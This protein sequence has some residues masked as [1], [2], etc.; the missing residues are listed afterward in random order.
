[1]LGLEKQRG[2][3]CLSLKYVHGRSIL[4]WRCAFG[5]QWE[6]RPENIVRGDWCPDCAGLN[7]TIEHMHVLAAEFRGRCLSA[8][9]V[10]AHTKLKWE[11]QNGHTWMAAP[12][13]V[14][15]GKWCSFCKGT[16]VHIQDMY[17]LAK[18]R[19]GMCLSSKYRGMHQHLSWQCAE[20][21][22]WKAVPGNVVRG[23]WCPAC[24][25]VPT[26]TIEEMRELARSRQGECISRE[27]TNMHTKLRWRCAEGHEWLAKPHNVK[28][29]GQWCRKCCT[30]ERFLMFKAN[31]EQVVE[32][33]EGEILSDFAASREKV[34]FR[35]AKGHTWN[36][37]ANNV[38]RGSWCKKC[39]HESRQKKPN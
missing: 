22:T 39:Y 10:T 29:L 13:D 6:Q 37:I 3:W 12:T 33:K 35:C 9:Y 5:H 2:G 7:K 11:C 32:D 28:H 27:Y 34:R 25:G 20:G 24:G 4:K 15:Q 30:H 38:V 36:A 23:R 19:G 21:H 18:A 16:R 14:Q 8:E 17:E 31:L 26:I 1:M